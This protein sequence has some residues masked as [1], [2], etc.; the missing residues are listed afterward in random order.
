MIVIV[1]VSQDIREVEEIYVLKGISRPF[2]F[3]SLSS[4]LPRTR[5]LAVSIALP[6]VCR[7]RAHAQTRHTAATRC[8]ICVRSE[9]ERLPSCGNLASMHREGSPR[10]SLT[11][12]R[13]SRSS[14][15]PRYTDFSECMPKSAPANK[16]LVMVH[17]SRPDDTSRV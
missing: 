7:K 15:K 2:L 14:T 6:E 4:L 9:Q 17:G 13:P 11:S 3:P 10:K 16:T 8:R 1:C 5:S 12:Q